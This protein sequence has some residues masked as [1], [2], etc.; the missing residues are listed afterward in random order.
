MFLGS[1]D[2]EDCCLMCPPTKADQVAPVRMTVDVIRV[3]SGRRARGRILDQI[4]SL[5][6][7]C[8]E[9][10]ELLVDEAFS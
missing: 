6:E 1:V 5:P 3:S 7:I 2:V 10:V 8:A 9:V 4:V